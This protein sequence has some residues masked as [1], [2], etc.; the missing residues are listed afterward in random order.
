MNYRVPHLGST[1]LFILGPSSRPSILSSNTLSLH[2]SI[3]T[4]SDLLCL[5]GHRL[6]KNTLI[7]IPR[8][9]LKMCK[10]SDCKIVINEENVQV[11][12]N[13]AQIKYVF[14]EAN[15]SQVLYLVIRT[16]NPGF[17][18]CHTEHDSGIFIRGIQ[19]TH[20]SH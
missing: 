13:C 11:Y 17:G 18:Y 19:H 6:Y 12:S 20:L 10:T 9:V 14:R 1:F 5:Y 8:I 16:Q 15:G 7:V 2:P 4:K 3:K